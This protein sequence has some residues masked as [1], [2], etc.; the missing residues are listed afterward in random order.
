MFKSECKEPL[1]KAPHHGEE[2][3][4]KLPKSFDGRDL[5]IKLMGLIRL[6]RY[7]GAF[8]I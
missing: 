7:K 1:S 6:S 2:L 5:E 8:S 4:L 3:G